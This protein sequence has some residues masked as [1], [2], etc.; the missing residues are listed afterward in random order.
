MAEMLAIGA[1]TVA[2]ARQMIRRLLFGF[3]AARLG[4]NLW[5]IVLDSWENLSMIHQPVGLRHHSCLSQLRRCG[6]GN[7]FESQLTFRTRLMAFK[8]STCGDEEI[9]I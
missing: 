1:A 7:D 3:K 8:S 4:E 6:T 2:I 9:Q 5:K